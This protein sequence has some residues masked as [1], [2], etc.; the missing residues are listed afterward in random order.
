MVLASIV[1]Y[2]TTDAN[3]ISNTMH[4]VM[5][6]KN[7]R[8]MTFFHYHVI[9][10]FDNLSFG[11]IS[12]SDAHRDEV[13]GSFTLFFFLNIISFLWRPLILVPLKMKNGTLSPIGCPLI[14][15]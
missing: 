6:L 10:I 4:C 9:W 11:S 2:I 13:N 8:F 15:M 1:K 14:C 12:A 7:F 5:K 3:V